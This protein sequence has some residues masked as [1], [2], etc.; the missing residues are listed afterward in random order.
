MLIKPFFLCLMGIIFL[1]GCSILSS[2]PYPV[3]YELNPKISSEI[4]FNIDGKSLFVA[5]PKAALG[6]D[7]ANQMYMREIYQL[8][9]YR[10]SQWIAP[11]AE[12]LLPLLVRYLEGTGAF[13]AVLAEGNSPVM[14]EWRL[15]TELLRL[16]QEFFTVPSQVRLQMRWQLLDLRKQKI[17][18]IQYVDVVIART[19]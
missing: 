11:P 16:Q 13:N 14:G 10:N 4:R 1:S 12:L 18:D 7:S 17:V 6:F 5:K 3:Y 9:H 15:D 8:E 2:K 19:Q